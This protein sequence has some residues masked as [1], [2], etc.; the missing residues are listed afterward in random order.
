MREDQSST[1][2][3]E[4]LQAIP[5]FRNLEDDDLEIIAAH[6]HKESFPK[7]A[8]VFQEGEMGDSMYLVESGQVQVIGQEEEEAIAKMGPGNFVGDIALLL[9]Q[10]RTAALEVTIDA[11]LWALK[12]DDF[13]DLIVTRP[14]IA[15]E[16]MRELSRRLVKTTRRKQQMGHRRI[17]ALAGSNES[18]ALPHAIYTQLKSPVGL[19]LLSKTQSARQDLLSSGV[20]ILDSNDLTEATFAEQLSHQI[21]VFRHVVLLLPDQPDPLVQ[22]AIDL[23]DTVVCIGQPPG[24]LADVDEKVELWVVDK[25]TTDLSRVARRLINRTVGLVLSSGGARGLAHIGVIKVLEEANIPIDMIA[26]SSA[27]ALFGALYAVGW[28]YERILQYIQELKSLTKIFNWDFNLPPFTGIVEG[29]KAYREFLK[30]PLGDRTFDSLK[31]PLYIVAADILTGEEVVFGYDPDPIPG[32]KTINGQLADAIRASV[33]IPVL[34]EPWEYEGHFLVDGGLVNPLPANVL[35]SRG[36]DIII[37][38]SVV[39]PLRDSYSGSRD[40]IPNVLQT[41]SNIF[42]AMESEIIKK[43]LPQID[44]LIHHNVAAKHTFDFDQAETLI[45]AG[46]EAARQMLPVIQ[47]I[48]EDPEGES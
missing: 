1:P 34:P 2:P 5:L 37:A 28:D 16:M 43:Q 17:T 6:L 11:Q 7:G 26:G 32:L 41:I 25:E 9:G 29:R 31:L 8:I 38:S 3:K 10:P 42:S 46:E 22:K 27:G 4:M 12:K 30:K 44:V 24:W 20:M 36:A 15:L 23:A 45:H 18:V 14:T 48:I 39:Q 21:E 19:L 33:S 35:R 40:K 13:D 47:K